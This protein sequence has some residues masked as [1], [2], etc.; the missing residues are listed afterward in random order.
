VGILKTLLFFFG[1][2]SGIV[3]AVSFTFY[4]F[5]HVFRANQLLKAKKETEKKIESEIDKSISIHLNEDILELNKTIERRD[6]L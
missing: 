2:I 3:S 6:I 1:Y 5:Y 4:S